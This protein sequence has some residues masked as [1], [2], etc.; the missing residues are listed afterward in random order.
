MLPF[1]Q[2]D[3]RLILRRNYETLQIESW[4][5]NSLRVRATLSP[6]LR[7]DWVSAL[8]PVDSVPTR[9]EIG[10]SEASVTNGQITALISTDGKLRFANATT[11]QE[12]LAERP[13]HALSVPAR[14]YQSVKGD[15]FHI[16]VKFAA[17][18]A[19]HF[20]GLGQHQEAKFDQKGSVIDLIQRNTEVTI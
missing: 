18:D 17:Y 7:E 11:G 9:I 10:E 14:Y 3:T 13:I 12:I 6:A 5:P 16:E 8:L 4:G 20:Y 1:Q 2:Y 15:L 19:E